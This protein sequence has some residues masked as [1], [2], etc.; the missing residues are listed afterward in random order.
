MLYWRIDEG[1]GQNIEDLSDYA[2]EGNIEHEEAWNPLEEEPMELEDKW[3]KKCPPQYSLGCQI[4]L[5][6]KLN[7]K[8]FNKG[9]SV[10]VWIKPFSQSFHIIT[11]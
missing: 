2:N 9:L 8:K 1:K 4:I 3:G 10:E 7:S 11:M 6:K 5:D